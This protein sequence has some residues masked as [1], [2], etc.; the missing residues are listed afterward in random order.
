M[1]EKGSLRQTEG[2]EEPK[3]ISSSISE[4][5]ILPSQFSSYSFLKVRRDLVGIV[6]KMLATTQNFAD[7]I[8]PRPS[9]ACFY[10][11]QHN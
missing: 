4:D 8:V 3:G 1:T 6:T 2:S 10:P 7:D 9:I 5:Q 11:L